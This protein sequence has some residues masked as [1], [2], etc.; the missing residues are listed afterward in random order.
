[1]SEEAAQQTL[2]VRGE[3]EATTE[4]AQ[5][6]KASTF[7]LGPEEGLASQ[8]DAYP[9]RP[10]SQPKAPA[11][12]PRERLSPPT[13][14]TR[15]TCWEWAWGRR[16]RRAAWF[17]CQGATGWCGCRR[18]AVG[19]VGTCQWA[20]CRVLCVVRVGMRGRGG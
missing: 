13:P 18:C 5:V 19:R 8:A 9:P 2:S 11:A 10:S 12:P 7:L 20:A 6:L 16:V 14:R 15:A 1:M 4:V 17:L 3:G